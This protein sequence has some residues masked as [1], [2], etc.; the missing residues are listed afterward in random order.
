[1]LFLVTGLFF[2]VL[3]L[4]N[5]WRSPSLRFQ[6]SDFSIFCIMCHVPGICV[7]FSAYIKSFPGMASK[8]FH[9][10]FVTIPVA[11]VIASII[12]HLK[13][14]IHYISIHKLLYFSFF[15]PAFCTTFLST[16]TATSII[17]HVFIFL[18]LIIMC[19]LF[20][21]TSVCVCTARFHNTVTSS[22]SYTDMD[23]CVC[24]YHLSVISVPRA[25]YIQ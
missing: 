4:L 2:L 9:K 24:V 8:F 14:Y 5:Q 25:L 1:M 15:S 21:V 23:V 20:S 10:P 18:L 13:F 17:M 19:F 11:A 12:I 7:F 22:C 3:L 16:A 6:A